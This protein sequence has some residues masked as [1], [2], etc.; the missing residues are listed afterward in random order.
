MNQAETFEW[1]RERSNRLEAV[2][3]E[4]DSLLKQVELQAA[5][6]K[7]ANDKWINYETNY[8]LPCFKWAEEMDIDLQA[9]VRQADGNCVAQLVHTLRERVESQ[10]TELERLREHYNHCDLRSTHEPTGTN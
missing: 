2:E 10:A 4:R 3:A 6:L 1:L 8:I 7:R 9:L 5:E